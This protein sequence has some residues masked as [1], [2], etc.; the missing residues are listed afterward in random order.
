MLAKSSYYKILR[1]AELSNLSN[2]SLRSY[3][4]NGIKEA[5]RVV[6][7]NRGRKIS[8]FTKKIIINENNKEIIIPYLML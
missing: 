7:C 8:R 2:D 5:N 6:K 1:K 4:S 3:G